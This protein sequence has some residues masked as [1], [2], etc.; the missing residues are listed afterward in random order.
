MHESLCGGRTFH[1]LNGIDDSSLKCFGSKQIFYTSPASHS[2]V[3]KPERVSWAPIDD[4][5]G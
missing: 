5:D 2:H 1:M 3:R 4:S